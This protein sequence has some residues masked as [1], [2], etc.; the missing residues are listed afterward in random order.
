MIKHDENGV[1]FRTYSI[2]VDINAT[3]GAS[4]ETPNRDSLP[5]GG[6]ALDELIKQD[7]IETGRSYDELLNEAPQNYPE[8]YREYAEQI[9]FKAY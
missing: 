9:G 3:G 1:E 7:M 5:F 8:E 6:S 2:E 4:N